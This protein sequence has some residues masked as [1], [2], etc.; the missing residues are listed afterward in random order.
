MGVTG[1]GK[2]GAPRAL[3]PTGLQKARCIWVIDYGTQE[4]IY[5][6]IKKLVHK[7]SLTFELSE[8]LHVFDEQKGEQ[9][10]V[11]S[12]R[13]T[14]SVHEKAMA[15]AFI[16]GWFGRKLTPAEVER[17][18]FATLLNK[19]GM[20]NIVIAPDKKDP[21]IKYANISSISPMIKGSTMVK[22]INPF[23]DYCIGAANQW[24]EF[25]KIHPKLQ[26][27][28]MLSPEWQSEAAK[29]GYKA[30]TAEE[31]TASVQEPIEEEEQF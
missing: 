25:E 9:P 11:L 31:A 8:L 6:G 29:V 30:K 23:I 7:V 1:S 20:V 22:A 24:T 18:D 26:E 3:P 15:R 17:F 4:Q 27:K 10:F 13:L 12:Q 28:I 16:E 19:A 21:N 5:K 14:A 2:G